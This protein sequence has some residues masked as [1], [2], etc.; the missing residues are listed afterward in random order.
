MWYAG[1]DWADT[2]HDVV[3]LNAD[4]QRVAATQVAHSAEGIEQLRMLLLATIQRSAASPEPDP[5]Q[6]ACIIE[7]THGLLI[8]ALLESGFP[9]YPVNPKTV[10]RLR[11]PSGA[12]T[13][14]IDATLL[15]R[16]G[17]NDLARLRRLAPDS[18]LVQELKTLTRDQES[19]V[20]LQTR[21]INQLTACLKAYYP[22]A[23][24]LFSR[25]QQPLTLTF[26]LRYP[27]MAAAQAAASEELC[28]FLR[29]VVPTY[30]GPAR[31]AE[32]IWQQI[33]RPHLVADPI[34]ERVKARL[35]CALVQQ[36]LPLIEQIAAYDKEIERLFRQHADAPLF[37]SLPG[38]G[39]RLAPRL[40]AEW[41]DDRERYARAQSV[42]GLAGTAP[43]SFQS[44]NYRR[45]HRRYACVKPLR[46][47]LHQF[48]WQSTTQ[49]DWALAYYKQKRAQGKSHTVALRALANL[50]VRIIYA[51]WRKHEVYAASVFLAAQRAHAQAVA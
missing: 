44:G 37:R 25:L 28:A 21:L 12:K 48:A 49:E 5:E 42:Q 22:A 46:N 19:L 6:M 3:I 31:A 35:A 1:I 11:G 33:Q 17:R 47:V 41:G 2:H 7:T 30:R 51:M 39:V 32:R 26:L 50:W 23:L 45:A 10:D 20:R 24:Q 38:A 13:D 16:A 15:A 14:Q 36:L 43:V 27:T 4:G 18:A 34:T 40:L 29:S 8:T 9:V